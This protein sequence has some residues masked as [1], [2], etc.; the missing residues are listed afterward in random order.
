MLVNWK[1]VAQKQMQPADVVPKWLETDLPCRLEKVLECD[2]ANRFYYRN[3]AEFTIGR[4]LKGQIAVGFNR[5]NFA[6]GNIYIESADECPIVSHESL[7]ISRE[8]A[9]HIEESQVPPY[10][11]LKGTGVWKYIIVR[12]SNVT[13]SVLVNIVIYVKELQP[14]Q[15]D[16]IK[17]GVLDLFLKKIDLKEHKLVSLSVQYCE[18]MGEGVRSTDKLEVLHGDTYFIETILGKQFKVSANAFLQV[19]TPQCN[20]LYGLL[21]EILKE[22]GQLNQNTIFLDICSGIGTIGMCLADQCE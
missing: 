22:T 18:T 3:K 20:K 7:L 4:N 8:F 14:A 12:Q 1:A 9:K 17:Q 15:I 16:A 13:K 6:K 21:G 19:N 11:R 5:G 2:E 10:D